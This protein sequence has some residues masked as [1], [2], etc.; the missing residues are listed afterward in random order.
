M[1]RKVLVLCQRKSSKVSDEKVK[2][3]LKQIDTKYT[4]LSSSKQ[5]V[6]YEFLTPC[7]EEDKD[8]ENCADHKIQFDMTNK[9]V[10]E[11][12]EMRKNYYSSVIL[13][14]CPLVYILNKD[15]LDG[16]WKLLE[17]EGSVYVMANT[18]SG[19]VRSD[20]IKKSLNIGDRDG[21]K[22]VKL[23]EQRFDIGDDKDISIW[24]KKE[25]IEDETETTLTTDEYN[26][27]FEVAFMSN[28]EEGV[29]PKD[30]Y[31]LEKE[32][33]EHIPSS[34]DLSV[35]KMISAKI[36]E[37]INIE[38]GS[39]ESLINMANAILRILQ[40]PS[41]YSPIFVGNT[42]KKRLELIDIINAIVI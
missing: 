15:F 16:I 41:N 38:E 12:V 22:V 34:T 32:M 18:N 39:R 30:L 4:V 5:G 23:I 25:K 2:K 28:I 42:N 8:D 33:G 20:F 31:I 19:L 7:L 24:K 27:R 37:S 13:Y 1:T 29:V 3:S 6:E 35:Y 26:R 9:K 14:T 40:K 10:V 36:K 11:W 21:E 17:K